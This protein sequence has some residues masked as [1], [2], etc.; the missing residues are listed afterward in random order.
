[1]YMTSSF[2]S[3]SFVRLFG[4]SIFLKTDISCNNCYGGIYNL[5]VVKKT[6]VRRAI[7]LYNSRCSPVSF[8]C[9]GPD[10]SLSRRGSASQNHP[11]RLAPRHL[12]K[13]IHINTITNYFNN[14]LPIK[15]NLISLLIPHN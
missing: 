1:M 6:F 12:V 15:H 5:H 10:P 11:C 14:V 3:I 4:P 2:W 7:M 8:L 13:R 9:A